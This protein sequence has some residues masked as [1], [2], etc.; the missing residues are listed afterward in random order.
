MDFK[1]DT[2]EAKT[3]EDPVELPSDTLAILHEF[4]QSKNIRESV[5][6][7]QQEYFEENWVI[8]WCG[9][10]SIIKLVIFSNIFAN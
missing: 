6:E 7:S 1:G 4:L 8:F 9:Y 10:L 3:D 5:E 2:N